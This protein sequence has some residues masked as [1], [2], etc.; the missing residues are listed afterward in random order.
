MQKCNFTSF[1]F[2]KVKHILSNILP[3]L[4]KGTTLKSVLLIIIFLMKEGLSGLEVASKHGF[5]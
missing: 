4:Q 2:L 3:S 1:E 5:N